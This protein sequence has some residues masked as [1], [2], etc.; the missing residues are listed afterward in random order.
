MFGQTWSH[1]TIRK[2]VI[3]FGTLFDSI[4]INRKNNAGETVQTLKIPLNYGPKEKFLARLNSDS[5]LSQSTAVTLP[6][7][8]FDMTTMNYAAE[9]KQ[10]TINR[11]TKAYASDNS[12]VSYQYAPVPYDFTFSLYVMVKNADDGTQI[13]EQILPYF[14]PEWTATVN[15]V[16]GIDGKFDIPII[17]NDVSMEDTYEGNFETRRAIIYTLTFTMKGWLFGP[18]KTSDIIKEINV[19]IR[20]PNTD[21]LPIVANTAIGNSV[22]ITVTPGL[23]ANGEPTSNAAASVSSDSIAV[24]DNYGFIVDFEENM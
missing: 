22:V 10:N 12:K 20:I 3:L 6:R 13:I 14:T 18:T 11:L 1:D 19:D 23:T 8:A 15:L 21:V 16:P 9:R 24:G 7:M 5:T 4:Y 17:L 2:Y